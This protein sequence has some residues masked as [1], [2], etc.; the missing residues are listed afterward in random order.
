M[1]K[2]GIRNQIKALIARNDT[3]DAIIDSFI[4]QAIARIQRT[5]RVPPMEKMLVTTTTTTNPEIIVLPND[6]L[7]LKHLYISNAPIEYVD[8][9]TFLKT[10]DAPGNTPRI[11]TR[12]QGSYLLKPTPPAGLTINMVYY[13]EIPDL[14]N[15]TDTNFISEIAPDLLI[16]G[17][18]SFAA[19]YYIDDRRAAFEEVA[20]R[21]YGE[22][23]AQTID[24]E[25]SQEGLVVANSF[26]SPE[27]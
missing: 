19:D 9:G 6:F 11:Y 8:V 26:N 5:L 3:T 4:D 21:A 15:D 2:L 23:E 18:L 12:I 13:G 22:L 27:Y 24:L 7:K 17:A 20:Q 10:Q 16:Y 14:V 1:N 25:F